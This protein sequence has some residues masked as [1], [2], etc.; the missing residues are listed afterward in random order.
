MSGIKL[1][2]LNMTVGDPE[3]AAAVGSQALQDARSLRSRRAADDLRDLGRRATVHEG[4]HQVD[5]LRNDI[6]NALVAS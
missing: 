3:E 2:S 5:A 4:I 6:R 1:A